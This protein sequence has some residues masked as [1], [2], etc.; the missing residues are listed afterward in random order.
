MLE[1]A[2]QKQM[3]ERSLGA[4]EPVGMI[5]VTDEEPA[6]FVEKGRT[7]IARDQRPA[8]TAVWHSPIARVSNNLTLAWIAR[9]DATGPTY[10]SHPPKHYVALPYFPHPVEQYS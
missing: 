3:H 7:G 1:D 8:S 2:Q 5:I 6:I 10:S 9:E 4:A